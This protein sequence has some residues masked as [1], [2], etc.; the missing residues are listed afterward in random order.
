[1]STQVN[2]VNLGTFPNDGT[3]DDLR[4]AFEKINN[5]VVLTVENLGEGAPLFVGKSY[6]ALEFRSIISSNE[7]LTITHNGETVVLTVPDSIKN[8]QGDPEPKLGGDLDLNGYDIIGEGNFIGNV[9]GTVSSIENHGIEDLG[10]VSTDVPNVGDVLIWTGNEWK[11]RTGVSN[12]FDFGVLGQSI[13]NP[14][15]LYLQ[16]SVIDLGTITAPTT[17]VIDLNFISNQVT[18]LL[19]SN[20]TTVVKGQTV[21]FTVF[22]NNEV[23]GTVIDYEIS[24]VT[25]LELNQPLTGSLTII[26]GIAFLDIEVPGSLIL[27]N[28]T[29]FLTF[30]LPEKGLFLSLVIE[31]AQIIDGGGPDTIPTFIVDGGPA[32]GLDQD[33]VYDG[34]VIE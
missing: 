19:D 25:E 33:T 29:R 18:Y 10:N 31:E 17:N 6:N 2:L 3:G 34:G 12:D 15:E 30:G 4:T 27:G 24:G 5:N 8:V 32:D 13:K 22:A 1:M 7:N 26:N 14:L 21:R 28:E 9:I 20:R 16:F 23:D 11:P